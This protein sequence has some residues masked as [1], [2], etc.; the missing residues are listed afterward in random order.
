MSSFPFFLK[1]E[2][3]QDNGN[4]Q[5]NTKDILSNKSNSG[6]DEVDKDRSIRT[7]LFCADIQEVNTHIA[8]VLPLVKYP[9]HSLIIFHIIFS[10][11]TCRMRK[12]CQILKGTCLIL[13][14][15]IMWTEK[16]WWR[17]VLVE[18]THLNY[19]WYVVNGSVTQCFC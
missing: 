1:D 17:A 9:F 16:T 13:K 8:H 12:T 18:K 14:M 11:I 10:F 6:P 5:T 2:D 4:D 15:K 3:D 7:S 19:Q